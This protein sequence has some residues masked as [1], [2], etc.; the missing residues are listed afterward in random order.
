MLS[1]IPHSTI[2]IRE[3]TDRMMRKSCAIIINKEAII[4]KESILPYNNN[5]CSMIINNAN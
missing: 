5:D 1:K 3:Y 2:Y 4:L